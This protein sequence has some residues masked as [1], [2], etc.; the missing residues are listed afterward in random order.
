MGRLALALWSLCCATATAVAQ[1]VVYTFVGDSPDD[2][3]GGSVDV[4]S[5]IDGDGL[6]ELVVGSPGDPVRQV[7][8]FSGADGGFLFALHGPNP[9]EQFGRWVAGLGDVDGDG[10]GDFAVSAP[11][12]G[13]TRVYSGASQT[14]L[15]QWNVP[16]QRLA[17]VGDADGDGFDD[18]AVAS[19]FHPNHQVRLFSGGTGNLLHHWTGGISFG[20]SVDGAGDVNGD[21]YADVVVG[22]HF[23]SGTGGPESGRVFVYSGVD[24]GLL[25]LFEG[26]DQYQWFGETVAGVGDVNGDGYDDLLATAEIEH[27]FVWDDP[28][29]RVFSGLDGSILHEFVYPLCMGFLGAAASDA[30]DVDGDGLD[31]FLLGGNDGCGDEF[32]ALHS[33]GSGARLWTIDVKMTHESLEPTGD[34]NG[35]GI[36]DFITGDRGDTF[37]GDDAGRAE[38]RSL[39]CSVFPQR[40]C[41]PAPN[42]AGPGAS[43]GWGGSLSLSQNDL[44]LSAAGCPPGAYGVFFYGPLATQVP[45]GD[46]YR[47][48]AGGGLGIFRLYPPVPT[49]PGGAVEIATDST[50]PPMGSGPGT[51]GAGETWHFQFWYRDVPAGLSGF[52]LTD[53]LGLTFCP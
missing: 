25:H 26:D 40:Y 37:G 13:Y 1:D 19:S 14:V 4:A 7:R 49:D 27:L 20:T 42:S 33:G 29:V 11:S 35:D 53:A 44:R 15:F 48:V 22:S 45:F 47:C 2:L 28:Y 34:V 24:G 41:P 3:L 52:N 23:E 8:V 32:L 21:G 12:G 10:S 5:D 17:N 9:G 6:P 38:V 16:S 46:G 18:L 31:D 43:I 50:A 30:G 36:A 51:L 39:F